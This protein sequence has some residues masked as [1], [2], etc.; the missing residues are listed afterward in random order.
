[1]PRTQAHTG[2]DLSHHPWVRNPERG[3]MFRGVTVVLITMCILVAACGSQVSNT[4]AGSSILASDARTSKPGDGGLEALV[5][6]VPVR[7]DVRKNPIL[8]SDFARADEQWSFTVPR[9]DDDQAWIGYAGD[10]SRRAGVVVPESVLCKSCMLR[11][12]VEGSSSGHQSAVGAVHDAFGWYPADV[13]GAAEA[14]QIPS[15][16]RILE[17]NLDLS[18]VDHAFRDDPISG[19]TL[20]IV[21]HDGDKVYD[22]TCEST[23]ICHKKN[24][25]DELGRDVRLYANSTSAVMSLDKDALFAAIDTHADRQPGL[26]SDPTVAAIVAALDHEQTYSAAVL[27]PGSIAG[28]RTALGIGVR[29]DPGAS[30]PTLVV[31]A[32]NDPAAAQRRADLLRTWAAGGTIILTNGPV[33]NAIRV[34]DIHVDGTL[35][36]GSFPITGNDTQLW[37]TLVESY[38]LPFAK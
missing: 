2:R 3:G 12:L 32:D 20:S 29:R 21:D 11:G 28:N 33:A 17:G 38:D 30:K 23:K 35:T 22:S 8:L 9:R 6:W 1:M 36:V 24:A 31:V 25:K 15:D 19:P 7:D 16:L 34:G 5:R 18:A 27:M 10:L 26:A 14:G 4:D 13:T 37:W